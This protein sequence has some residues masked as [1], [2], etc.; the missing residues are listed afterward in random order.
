MA[1]ELMDL[2]LLEDARLSFQDQHNQWVKIFEEAKHAL[3]GHQMKGGLYA[4]YEKALVNGIFNNLNNYYL[5]SVEP[6]GAGTV[7]AQRE[8]LYQIAI[9]KNPVRMFEVL[10]REA[11]Q[12]S[13]VM[14]AYKELQADLKLSIIARLTNVERAGMNSV[15]AVENKVAGRVLA[16]L[17]GFGPVGIGMAAA[18]VVVAAKTWL[19]DLPEDPSAPQITAL[20]KYVNEHG[21]VHANDVSMPQYTNVGGLDG[22]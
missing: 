10:E 2:K 5:S 19:D 15:L 3:A 4:N 13:E 21:V 9:E 18:E 22:P 16:F 14:F 1:A 6:G 17:E 11:A 20:R 8:R 7:V 12:R